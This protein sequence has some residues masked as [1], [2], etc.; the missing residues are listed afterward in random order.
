M[1]TA[2]LVVG[3]SLAMI[4]GA[5]AATITNKDSN[6]H[7]LTVTEG[8][9]QSDMVV[10]AGATVNFCPAGCF[11]TM[12]SGDRETLSGSENVEIINGGAVIK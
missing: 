6:S 2:I 4:G 8:S 9:N 10:E 3:L 11:V 5:A 12:P 1:K 7:V